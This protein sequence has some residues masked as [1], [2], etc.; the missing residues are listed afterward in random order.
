MPGPVSG[1]PRRDEDEQLV[2]EAR[3]SRKAAA[4]VGPP[5]SSSDWTPSAASA[6]SSSASG[7]DRSSSS[8]PSGSGPLPNAI[9]RGCRPL[10]RRERRAAGCRQR[11]VPM[12]TATAS[13]C[14]RS[15]CTSRRESSPVT[16]RESGTRHATVER[17]RDLVRHERPL[18]ASPTSAT[19]RSADD[20]EK[21]CRPRRAR[22]RRRRFAEQ[23]ETAAVRRIRIEL[24]A[25]RRPRRP[26]R[27][28]RRRTAA[29]PRGAAQGSSVTYTVAPRARS[30]A[31]ARA[32]TSACG[33][34][35]RSCQPSPTIS[36]SLTMTAPTTGLGRVVP[37][38]R[39]ASSMAR[40]R[41][42][43]SMARILRRRHRL[44][45]W[46]FLADLRLTGVPS[47]PGWMRCPDWSP[48]AQSSGR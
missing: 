12:P 41:K 2:D 45:E 44:S 7:P 43:G 13:D 25:R 16:Q 22:R 19:P 31:S 24:T 47:G 29:S 30:P 39:S 1:E 11:T 32:T 17:D 8:D 15:T 36:P 10:G 9:R 3:A 33:P 28:A 18:R 35:L 23:L 5:S 14:A 37:R 48:T 40:S 46:S 6:S 26:P 42:R 27:A 34:P 38:P 4:R 21:Q 20:N